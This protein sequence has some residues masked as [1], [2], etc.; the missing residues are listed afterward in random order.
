MIILFE[1]NEVLFNGLGLG[2]IKDAKS[3]QVLED[4]KDCSFELEMVYPY[5]GT[6]Y[7]SLK[8]DRIIYTPPNPYDEA[9]PF[10]IYSIS[11]PIKGYVTV[12]AQHISYDMNGIPVKPISGN[13]LRDTI[14]KIQNGSIIDNNFKIYTE[15]SSSKTFKTTNIY[16]MRAL[17]MGGDESLL[18]V[19]ELEAKFNKFNIYLTEKRGANRGATVAYAK[20][21]KDITHEINYERLY[22]GVYPFYHQETTETKTDVAS[23]EFKQVYIVGSKPFQDGWLSYT[24]GGEPYHPIDESPVQVATEGNYNK[25]VYCWNTNLQRY[26]EKVY[27]DMFTLVD[28]VTGLLNQNSDVPQWVTVDW[29]S[30]TSLKL[31]LKAGEDGYFKMSTESEWTYHKK[32]EV[33]FE[34]SI[35]D[36]AS[37]LIVYYSEVIPNNTE[38][39]VEE[40]TNVTHIELDDKIIWID[41]PLAKA[42]KF[43]RILTLDLTSEFDEAPDQDSLKAKANEYIEKNKIGQYKFETDVSFVDLENTTE[44][45]KYSNLNHIEIGDIV[46]VMYNSVGI[47]VELRVVSTLYD[48]LNN[49]YIT[50]TLGES[51]EKLSSGSIQNGDNISSLTNDVGFADISTVNKLVAKI[52]TADYIKAKNAELSKAQIEQLESARIKCS[53]IIEASQ[54]EID[55]LVAK[56]LTADNAIIKQTLEAGTIKVSGDITINSGAITI[57]NDSVGT[58]FKVDRD[59]N[60]EANSLKLTG[61]SINIQG[62]FEV[63]NDGYLTAMNAKIEGEIIANSGFIAGFNI[64]EANISYVDTYFN[65]KR[66]YIGTDKIELGAINNPNFRVTNEGVLT[67]VNVNLT[68]VIHATAGGTIGGFDIYQG[69]IKYENPTDL[70]KRIYIGTTKIELGSNSNPKFRVTND[71]ILMATDAVLSG[72]VT[73]SS[74]TIAGMTINSTNL[75]YYDSNGRVYIGTDKIELGP[76]A[77]PKF[78]V[79]KDGI[80][81][82]TDA[83]LSGSVTASSGTIGGFAISSTGL[84]GADLGT[85]HR[86]SITPSG[87]YSGSK[88]DLYM[89]SSHWSYQDIYNGYNGPYPGVL[90][91]RGG[92]MLV[93][94]FQSGSGSQEVNYILPLCAMVT[95]AF[96][97]AN[98]PIQIG[99]EVIDV[100]SQAGT[101]YVDIKNTN[102]NVLAAVASFRGNNAEASSVS[103]TWSS[104]RI[105]YSKKSTDSATQIVIIYICSAKAR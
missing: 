26:Q 53:G 71:G 58:A 85:S 102:G 11:K 1:E 44:G 35:K 41:T 69:C 103:V 61:G 87:E 28:S 4:T 7:E 66:V 40:S 94:G 46:R 13:G 3:C 47:D 17:L 5:S 97:T 32:G 50:I 99:Y 101:G 42:M 96:G 88:I 51:P 22:N 65:N 45:I 105:T 63:T 90:M 36:V 68:G 27:N 37:A 72:S 8:I 6:R 43:N 75:T 95:Q 16:N 23:G 56:L 9:E 70:N 77:N 15:K 38:S 54:F 31:V 60:V 78:V 81:T 55:N 84:T 104:K 73:A 89:S 82:A 29:Q 19:Y 52:V 21:L 93:E 34:G 83:V 18:S 79:T 48:A 98:C 30:L 10:R 24:E 100:S 86:V 59:G 74:G 12:K 67:A 57:K 49:K 62:T 20:N 14:D 2:I 80:L 64:N 25:K 91:F 33:V 76:S 39:T 92:E